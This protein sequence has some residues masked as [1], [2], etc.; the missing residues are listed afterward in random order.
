MLE[1]VTLEDIVTGHLP[2]MVRA[3]TENPSAWV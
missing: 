2:E 1:K 3:L